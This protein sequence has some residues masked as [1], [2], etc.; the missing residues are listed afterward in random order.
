MPAI[1]LFVS[2]A[3]PQIHEVKVLRER[4]KWLSGSILMH[5]LLQKKNWFIQE[6][7][8]KILTLIIRYVETVPQFGS[9]VR[10]LQGDHIW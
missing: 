10:N 5:R 4:L 6:K 9:Y 1:V 7:S 2:G 8:C 3:L